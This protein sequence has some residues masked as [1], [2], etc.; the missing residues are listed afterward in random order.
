MFS[1][2]P[3][4]W[5][6][7]VHLFKLLNTFYPAQIWNYKGVYLI[8]TSK[9]I[10]FKIKDSTEDA[11]A[12]ISIYRNKHLGKKCIHILS[13]NNETNEQVYIDSELSN[14]ELDKN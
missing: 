10:T 8:D 1:P 9:D 11:K 14:L 6:V 7:I 4:L 12:V 5:I 3:L 2:L 13:E